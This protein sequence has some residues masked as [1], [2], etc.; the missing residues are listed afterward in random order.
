ML[1]LRLVEGLGV[2]VEYT[3]KKITVASRTISETLG[4][5]KSALISFENLSMALEF[6]VITNTPVGVIVGLPALESIQNCIDLR[7]QTVTM[8]YSKDIAKLPL[9][10]EPTKS[11]HNIA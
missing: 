8:K 2:K 4:I 1:S 10:L 9:N 11:T 6:L 5:V 3:T 7:A